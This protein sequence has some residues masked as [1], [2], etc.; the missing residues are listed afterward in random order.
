VGQRFGTKVADGDG[1]R[2]ILCSLNGDKSVG[3]GGRH[4]IGTKDAAFDNESFSHGFL[5]SLNVGVMIEVYCATIENS[6]TSIDD[7]IAFI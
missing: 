1:A 7:I 4:G 5:V 3:H 2:R 6:S